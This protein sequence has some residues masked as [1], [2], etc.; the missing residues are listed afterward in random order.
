MLKVNFLKKIRVVL[1]QLNEG[2]VFTFNELKT[3]KFRTFLSLLS[4]SIGI[5]TIIAIL[6]AVDTLEKGVRQSFESVN[7][8]QVTVS[9]WPISP[10]DENGNQSVEGASGA[11]EYRWWEY[12]RRPNITYDDYKFLKN[13]L[14]T[15]EAVI[16]NAVNSATAKKGRKSI[17]S[18]TTNMVTD[19]YEKSQ[20]IKI[21]SGRNMVASEIESGAAVAV[22]GNE[23]A[24]T[25]FDGEDPI[26]QTFTLKG[27]ILVVVGVLEREGESLFDSMSD[28]AQI[29]IP[30]H[31]G[32]II[33][34]VRESDGD[35]HA[36]AKENCTNEDLEEEIKLLLRNYRRLS[37]TD[38]L[39]FS[40]NQYNLL[41]DLIKTVISSLSTVG[42]IIAAFS[43]LIGGFGIANIK[44]VYV[45][46]RTRIIGIQKAL[47]A[48]KYFIMVQFLTEAV[49]MA[50]VGAVLGL[51]LVA[52]LIW[53][54]PF[55]PTYPVSLSLYNIFLGIAVAS[56]IGILSG[57]IPAYRAANLNP[58]DAINSK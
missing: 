19:G 53:I 51:L 48:K 35:I 55:P 27:H 30:Y 15:A 24:Q 29:Y 25:L 8:N 20:N 5:F 28:D 39:N 10:E 33:F 11:V 31:R 9:K 23:V 13:S 45:K 52:F 32:Q 47:G 40:V 16:Y 44:F 3:N 2:L 21:S 6:T 14:T 22:I 17:N 37:P 46:E 34:S 1:R 4:V 7:T 36:I 43:L 57:A 58:V 50:I 38:K 56:V 12:M 18:V 26:G 54:I 49:I 41:E 42:W